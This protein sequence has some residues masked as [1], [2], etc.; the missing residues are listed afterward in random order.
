MHVC[1]KHTLHA[2][3]L[4]GL[5]ILVRQSRQD[6]YIRVGQVSQDNLVGFDCVRQSGTLGWIGQSILIGYGRVG[7]DC[8]GRKGMVGRTLWLRAK[9]DLSKFWNFNPRFLVFGYA[10]F[11]MSSQQVLFRILATQGENEFGKNQLG[12]LYPIYR[13][14]I[15]PNNKKQYKKN[16][17]IGIQ[18][19]LKI[20]LTQFG[21]DF[22]KSFLRK[23]PFVM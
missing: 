4:V 23:I 5:G 7:Q 9:N 3:G 12:P 14:N 18:T 17:Q 15:H 11:S 16:M 6:R 10:M 8:Y 2:S 20:G 1:K 13:S 22:E 21:P 19:K